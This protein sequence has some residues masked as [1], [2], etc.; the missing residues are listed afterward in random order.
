MKQCRVIAA[1][2]AASRRIQ[3]AQRLRRI[4]THYALCA[5]F[6][7]KYYTFL[8]TVYCY[9]LFRGANRSATMCQP[10]RFDGRFQV[11]KSGNLLHSL[12]VAAKSRLLST[13]GGI[14]SVQIREWAI[15][16]EWT[17]FIAGPVTREHLN[18]R[19]MD[20]F[21]ECL[22][23]FCLKN[24]RY[25]HLKL[26]DHLSQSVLRCS[27]QVF[28]FI[29]MCYVYTNQ[30]FLPIFMLTRGGRQSQL[31]VKH[32]FLPLLIPQISLF[33]FKTY[34]SYGDSWSFF[35]TIFSDLGPTL[36]FTCRIFEELSI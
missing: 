8:F 28:T 1:G 20:A 10:V 17:R 33:F 36:Y 7:A 24:V 34:T 31:S 11:S 18:G 23:R 29:C 12:I 3:P 25:F 32:Y 15:R 2:R 19:L 13:L 21:S 35:Q 14:G 4:I 27:F 30:Q 5:D 9:R 6:H 16:A 26:C 22:K